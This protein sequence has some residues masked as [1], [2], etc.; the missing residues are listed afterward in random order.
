MK[1]LVHKEVRVVDNRTSAACQPATSMDPHLSDIF[2]EKT[3]FH[4]H[5]RQGSILEHLPTQ[6]C[7]CCK[8]EVKAVFS[9]RFP[10]QGPCLKTDSRHASPVVKD[11]LPGLQGLRCHQPSCSNRRA[12][13]RHS[14]EDGI[15]RTLSGTRLQLSSYSTCL[16]GHLF[17]QRH[18]LSF[19]AQN[20]PQFSRPH[21][22]LPI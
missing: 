12:S 8:S 5:D 14:I 7:R 11:A 21:E 4:H 17:G 3:Y 2:G 16:S 10:G 15:L 6:E 9:G 13:V 1:N 22:Q 20:L 18:I 19:L